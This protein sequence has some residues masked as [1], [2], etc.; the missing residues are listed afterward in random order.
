ME[1]TLSLVW[2]IYLTRKSEFHRVLRLQ[3]KVSKKLEK[4]LVFFWKA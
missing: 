3:K 4:G 1:G 2:F